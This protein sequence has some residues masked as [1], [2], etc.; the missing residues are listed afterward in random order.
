VIIGTTGAN[1]IRGELGDDLII[2]IQGSDYLDGGAGTDTVDYFYST[3]GMTIN[4]NTRS[5]SSFSETDVIA[6]FE[7]LIAT[8]F[9][10]VITLSSDA[11]TVQPN[12]GNDT[13]DCQAGVDNITYYEA[14]FG[15]QAFLN[16][17][18]VYIASIFEVDTV[19]SFSCENII[20]TNHTDLIVGDASNNE[21]WG[22]F[23]NDT[24]IG[25]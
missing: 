18:K 4:F 3:V 24:F 5:A 7:N 1:V 21:F 15:I 16:A 23:S 10:D 13:V 11:N 14:P 25:E 17:T 2:G 8:R 6:N 12:R 22:N 20:G 19:V 9:N